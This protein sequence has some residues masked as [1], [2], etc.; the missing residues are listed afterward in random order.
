MCLYVDI[1]MELV[2][3][4]TPNFFVIWEVMFSSLTFKTSKQIRAYQL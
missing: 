4:S 3:S 1:Y 2:I